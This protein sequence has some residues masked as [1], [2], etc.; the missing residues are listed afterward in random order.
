MQVPLGGDPHTI[1]DLFLSGYREPLGGRGGRGLEL[2]T[3]LLEQDC[4]S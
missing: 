2:V 1:S 3:T 4:C